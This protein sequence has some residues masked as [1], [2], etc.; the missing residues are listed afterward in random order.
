MESRYDNIPIILY[1]T[2]LQFTRMI[3]KFKFNVNL[4][5]LTSLRWQNKIDQGDFGYTSIRIEPHEKA[6]KIGFMF[7]NK[8]GPSLLK[9]FIVIFQTVN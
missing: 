7:V 9:S 6:S 2:Y 5:K 4:L 1:G 8:A 3:Q